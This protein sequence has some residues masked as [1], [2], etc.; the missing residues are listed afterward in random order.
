MPHTP[1]R[2]DV[3]LQGLMVVPERH[4][5]ML[6][7]LLLALLTQGEHLPAITADLLPVSSHESAQG[8][9]PWH[10][11]ASALQVNYCGPST[12]RFLFKNARPL[13]ILENAAEHGASRVYL[14]R[15]ITRTAKT[16]I[17]LRQATRATAWCMGDQNSLH[18]LLQEL[19]HLG[20]L[21][22]HGFG[23][24]TGFSI[25]QDDA[26]IKQSWLR[27]VSTLEAIDPYHT[28]RVPV[29]GQSAPPYWDRKA[30]IAYWPVE[31]L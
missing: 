20:P 1:L 29:Q 11:L 23:R 25:S 12:A 24:V 15:G 6:D 27:P 5:P 3:Q 30:G 28:D 21:R 14:D 26:A 9:R 17:V 7:G 2:I 22:H 18:D 13:A 10:W 4:P 31:I 19:T 16:R 8:D